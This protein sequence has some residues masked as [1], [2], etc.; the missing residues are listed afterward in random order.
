MPSFLNLVAKDGFMPTMDTSGVLRSSIN[1][2]LEVLF[3][4]I[5]YAKE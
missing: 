2:R 5:F 1:V 4:E 3:D